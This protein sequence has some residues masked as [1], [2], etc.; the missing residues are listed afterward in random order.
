MYSIHSCEFR[1]NCFH[2]SFYFHVQNMTIENVHVT[3][4]QSIKVMVKKVVMIV[5]VNMSDMNMMN[6]SEEKILIE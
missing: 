3:Q 6:S 5:E 2:L 1:I 4:R